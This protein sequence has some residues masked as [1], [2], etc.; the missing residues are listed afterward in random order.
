MITKVKSQQIYYIPDTLFELNKY[1]C[2]F[3][4]IYIKNRKKKEFGPN[5]NNWVWLGLKPN[6]FGLWSTSFVKLD[7]D[8][9]WI[10]WTLLKDRIKKQVWYIT[11]RG[12]LCGH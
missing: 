11:T 4:K 6:L 1:I 3:F 7:F 8:P 5:Q 12:L 9:V 2:L 10:K